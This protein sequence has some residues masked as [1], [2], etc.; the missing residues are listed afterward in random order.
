FP[1]PTR[2]FIQSG[3]GCVGFVNPSDVLD[4]VAYRRYADPV[5]PG[6]VLIS[7]IAPGVVIPEKTNVVPRELCPRLLPRVGL[8][9]T[10]SGRQTPPGREASGGHVDA[11]FVPVTE[12][13]VVFDPANLRFVQLCGV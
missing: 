5:F 6:V 10:L 12:R 4:H 11:A 2:W 7:L 8:P 9:K 3:R 13:P 1:C